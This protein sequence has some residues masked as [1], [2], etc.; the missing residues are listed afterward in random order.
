MSYSYHHYSQQP[1]LNSLSNLNQTR[2]KF[3]AGRAFDLEDDLE[4]CP[5]LLSEE[6]LQSAT[7]YSSDHSSTSGS[8]ESSPLQSQIRPSPMLGQ[9]S[10]GMSPGRPSANRTRRAI[11][12]VDPA[13]GMRVASPP[14]AS[15]AKPLS[16]HPNH[17]P[18]T[19]SSRRTAW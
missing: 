12:I 15:P 8:P 16:F 1:M 5:S 10:P 9:L 2:A 3:D 11:V 17:V 18:A 14:L 13:T 7:S 19:A 6:E 4:F